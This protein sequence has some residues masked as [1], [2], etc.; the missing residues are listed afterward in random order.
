VAALIAARP[1]PA[2]AARR[3]LID[4]ETRLT[5]WVVAPSL[6]GATAFAETPAVASLVEGPPRPLSTPVAEL[7]PAHIDATVDDSGQ[8]AT[9]NIDAF[10]VMANWW[11]AA[12]RD[13]TS[14]LAALPSRESTHTA[15][16]RLPAANRLVVYVEGGCVTCVASNHHSP[17]SVDVTVVD[18]DALPTKSS[19]DDRKT[20]PSNLPA[21]YEDCLTEI[22]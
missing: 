12:V 18:L 17:L 20:V 16:T 11:D 1:D 7:S 21:G 5:L 3:E 2:S 8:L 10:D 9:G 14:L 15:A 4:L 22:W 19:A 6:Q 13:A